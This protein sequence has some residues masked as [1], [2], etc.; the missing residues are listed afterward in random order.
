[1][2]VKLGATA[3]VAAVGVIAVTFCY[4]KRC[5][6]YVIDYMEI[7]RYTNLMSLPFL[8]NDWIVSSPTTVTF[9]S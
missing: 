7:M 4:S 2:A 1:V 8:L 5:S 9:H 3:M 6:M